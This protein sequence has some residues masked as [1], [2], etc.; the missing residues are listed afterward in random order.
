MPD[1]LN[2]NELNAHDPFPSLLFFSSSFVRDC[3]FNRLALEVEVARLEEERLARE[4]G[5]P[6]PCLVHRTAGR[7][8]IKRVDTVCNSIAN[9]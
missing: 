9:K 8:T 7:V 2:E 1:D 6:T 4:E 3:D 5:A